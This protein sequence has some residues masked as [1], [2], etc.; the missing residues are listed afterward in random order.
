MHICW[1]YSSCHC[2]CVLYLVVCVLTSRQQLRGKPSVYICWSLQR[3]KDNKRGRSQTHSSVHHA[4]LLI[5]ASSIAATAAAHAQRT[6]AVMQLS[7]GCRQHTA[8]AYR[9]AAAPHAPGLPHAACMPTLAG[10]TSWQLTNLLHSS[11]N[12][13]PWLPTAYS[14]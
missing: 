13:A 3:G 5:C 2:F 14:S 10:T 6:P 11:P 7:T 1:I 4:Q 12:V 8:Q 9:A